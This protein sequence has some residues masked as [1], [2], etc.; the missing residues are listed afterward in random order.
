MF[1]QNYF[2]R[3]I[4]IYFHATFQTTT[5]CQSAPTSFWSIDVLRVILWF[6]LVISISNNG[7]LKSC[8]RF[9]IERS[10]IR[11]QQHDFKS[12]HFECRMVLFY[13]IWEKSRLFFHTYDVEKDQ[14]R[15]QFPIRPKKR[16]GRKPAARANE[17][18]P[19]HVAVEPITWTDLHL[20]GRIGNCTLVSVAIN[21]ND[22]NLYYEILLTL[23]L[24]III[25]KQSYYLYLFNFLH[26][27]SIL[28]GILLNK[29]PVLNI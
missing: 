6:K 15:V 9:F 18:G 2:I 24:P 22:P 28:I 21:K 14:T 10:E 19:L 4:Q 11:K 20:L 13:I 29:T 16:K 8:T 3:N 12:V 17:N 26:F 27:S 5:N 23:Q 25:Q 1:I 7:L